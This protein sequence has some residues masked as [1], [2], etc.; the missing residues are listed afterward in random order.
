[1]FYDIDF[2][3]VFAY[4]LTIS[5]FGS[6]LR[7]DTNANF[8]SINFPAMATPLPIV[9]AATTVPIPSPRIFP[10]AKYVIHAVINR[11]VTS[12]VIFTFEYGLFI[13]SDKSLGNRSVGIIGNLHR[14]D[15]AIPKQMIM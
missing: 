2:T 15:N 10:S 11:Q 9:N 13:I 6:L 14:L 4:Q 5:A 3:Q 12:N 7:N 1:M 8:L